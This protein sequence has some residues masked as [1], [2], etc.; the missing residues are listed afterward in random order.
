[1]SAAGCHNVC[2]KSKAEIWSPFLPRHVVAS[3]KFFWKR[4]QPFP[5]EPCSF[6]VLPCPNP[7]LCI[8]VLLG[9]STLLMSSK[10]GVSEPCS[11]ESSGKFVI[12][13]ITLENW[14]TWRDTEQSSSRYPG[15]GSVFVFVLSFS[16]RC[17]H[18]YIGHL[19]AGNRTT[20][21]IFIISQNGKQ[22]I[23]AWELSGLCWPWTVDVDDI[24]T[25]SLQSFRCSFSSAWS[26]CFFS[27]KLFLKLHFKPRKYFTSNENSS[28]FR[29]RL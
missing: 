23:A 3:S 29:C 5:R 8:R 24:F 1:M 17:P 6:C 16:L 26:K 28:S 4:K 19:I 22:T 12:N 27:V 14:H 25:P 15:C 13:F 2:L 7:S 21:E 11:V 18:L 9:A 20:V 10:I